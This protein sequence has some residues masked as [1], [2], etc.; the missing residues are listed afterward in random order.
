MNMAIYNIFK[1]FKDHYYTQGAASTLEYLDVWRGK[2]CLNPTYFDKILYIQ[3][4]S[5]MYE[6]G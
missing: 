5:G 3:V 1:Y 6:Q 4:G 2:K